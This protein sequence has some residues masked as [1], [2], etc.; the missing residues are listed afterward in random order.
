MTEQERL[1]AEIKRLKNILLDIEKAKANASTIE[2][3]TEP[4]PLKDKDVAEPPN[5][6]KQKLADNSSASKKKD[7]E[8]AW[9]WLFV[10]AFIFLTPMTI[11]IKEHNNLKQD[12]EIK[13]VTPRTQFKSAEDAD[14]IG[15]CLG[16]LSGING[17][18]WPSKISQEQLNYMYSHRDDAE[19]IDKITR[20][21]SV[22]ISGTQDIRTC[23]STYSNYERTLVTGFNSAL[24]FYLNARAS[25]NRVSVIT[26]LPACS[27]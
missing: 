15:K 19:T 22:C 5:R 24:T 6:P 2:E 18:E 26:V 12:K 9:G 4:S 1:E 23:L 10:I 25:R 11:A 21:Q 8:L 16:I 20:E 17:Y 3:G 27:N 7:A 13:S 14:I